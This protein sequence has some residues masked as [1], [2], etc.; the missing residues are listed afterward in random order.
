MKKILNFFIT[1]ILSI[2]VLLL[3]FLSTTGIETKKFNNLIT[4]KIKA[5]NAKV[6]LNLDTIKFKLDIRE[7]SLFLE[8]TNPSINF[9]EITL[10]LKNIKAYINFISVITSEN[11]F[12]KISLNFK[13]IDVTKIKKIS[14]ILKPSNFSSFLNNKLVEGNLDTQ[15]EFY[16]EKSNRIKN[17]ITKGSVTE[18]K[19]DFENDANLEDISFTFFAD[20]TDIIINNFLSKFGPLIIEDG[21]AKI[22]ISPEILIET[23]FSSNIK[24]KDEFKRELKFFSNYLNLNSIDDL[25]GKFTNSLSI[26]LDKTYKLKNYNYK[27][28]GKI[29]KA[30]LNLQDSTNNFSLNE[31]FDG[32]T[33]KDTEINASFNQNQNNINSKGKYSVNNENFL[34]FD[35]KSI[36][37]KEISKFKIY[38]DIDEKIEIDLLN[39]IK[40]ER[41][42]AKVSLEIEKLEEKLKFKYINYKEG[43]NSIVINDLKLKKGKFLNAKKVSVKT[44]SKKKLN[45]DFR[46]LFGKTIL[47]KGNIFDA[48]NLPRILNKK[49][50]ENNLENLNNDV[51]I[52]IENVI[53]PLSEKLS[54]FRLIGKIEKGK[55]VKIS[56]KGDFGD[57]NFLDITM[58]NDK[59]KKKKYLE[60][61]S[62]IT[63][64]LL[65][66]YS[67]FKGLTGGKLL[68]SAIIDKSSSISKLKIENFK[69]VNAPGM[70][71]LLTLADL[72]G[73][74]DLAEGEGISF[75]TLE[76][77]LEQS[78][79]LIKI[80]EILA[81]GPS[82][83]VLM[84]GYQDKNVTSLRGTLI[85]AKTLNKM[86][87]RI[88]L[89]GNI[90]IPKEVGEG[91]FGISFKM[92]GPK[93]KIKT[94]INPIRTITPRFIQK[95]IDRN[96]KIN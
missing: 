5:N 19:I 64:P 67:F 57:N 26:N 59:L 85:P 29:F 24:I 16:F 78:N 40:P 28:S 8:A 74:A 52:E 12:E 14:S 39:Y 13:Q 7:I 3:V 17:F 83:S 86:I 88:P 76:I 54:K 55:F 91:L 66:E 84:E 32:V 9:K 50:N 62:D 22:Q 81:L 69:V 34:N 53:A 44:F 6:N 2:F 72:G 61:Y 80:K 93:G 60:I 46:I 27:K 47:I 38:A 63:K 36:I 25:S 43:E 42:I 18:A 92:K 11:K 31:N 87:A 37:D 30:K 68:Y 48:S 70:V 15:I 35:L 89:I 10:P 94:S 4:K 23:N 95:I 77:D 96:K 41:K 20:N 21:D 73:L 58:K 51:E 1:L 56:S 65:T 90:V 71:K 79:E 49:N 82:I 33:L 45:N 75:E